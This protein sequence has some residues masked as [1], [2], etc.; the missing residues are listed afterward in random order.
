MSDAPFEF[1]PKIDL[2]EAVAVRFSG[3]PGDPALDFDVARRR[4]R[5]FIDIGEAARAGERESDRQDRD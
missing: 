3:L 5:N 4:G 1:V 2:V